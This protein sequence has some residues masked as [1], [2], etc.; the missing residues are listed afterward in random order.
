[1]IRSVLRRIPDGS[2]VQD[3]QKRL[4]ASM[5]ETPARGVRGPWPFRVLIWV[6][7]A[8]LVIQRL[9]EPVFFDLWQEIFDLKRFSNDR[10][11]A[12]FKVCLFPA[13]PLD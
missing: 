9:G 7:T 2:S 1:M 13:L 12:D 11:N 4:P 3:G 6:T 5:W 10:V 8:W